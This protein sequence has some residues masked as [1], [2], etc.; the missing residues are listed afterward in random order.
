M[1]EERTA[2]TGESPAPAYTVPAAPETTPIAPLSRPDWLCPMLALLLAALYWSVFAFEH[3][4]TSEFLPGVGVT[5]FVF[6]YFIAVFLVLGRRSYPLPGLLLMASALLLSI[7]CGLYCHPGLTVLNC[8]LIL[9]L[10]AAATFQLSGH[11]QTRWQD[12]RLLPESIRLSFQA[13]TGRLARPLQALKLLKKQENPGIRSLLWGL[14]IAIPVLAVVL[15]LLASADAVFAGLFQGLAKWL[16]ELELGYL[17]WKLFRWLLLGLF[18][19]SG[20]LFLSETPIHSSK[21]EKEPREA[22]ALPFLATTLLLD[23]VYILF[24]VIQ[25]RH[26]FGGWETAQM[27][28][29]WAEYART[30]FFQLVGVTVINLA[31]CLLPAGEERYASKGGL[32]LRLGGAL[33]TLLSFLILASAA[34]R[35]H[36]YIQAFGLSVLRILTV[37][38]IAVIALLLAAAGYKLLRPRFRFFQV[39]LVLSVIAWCLVNLLGPMRMAANYNVDAF[40][41]GRLSEVD[42][43]YMDTPDC[44]PALYRLGEAE[45][46]YPALANKTVYLEELAGWNQHYDFH[47]GNWRVAYLYSRDN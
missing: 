35:I 2:L 40:L 28:G 7:T 37:W 23:A 46:D 15:A 43:T 31:V 12:W 34:W 27:A 6:A 9:A 45:P 14:L 47:W 16:E 22:S 18:L 44:L 20:L 3:M 39:F 4:L 30:G 10:S 42:I 38:G 26:L 29:G 8:F 33:M 5:A 36:L 1:N 32:V 25:F 21:R 13:L 17:L 24:V 41:D 19:C 11:G